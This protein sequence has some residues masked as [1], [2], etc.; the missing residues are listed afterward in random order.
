MKTKLVFGFGS[1]I[2]TA[3][4]LVTS[5]HASDIRPAY[6]KGFRRDFSVWAKGGWSTTNLDLAGIP[7]CALDIQE[8][9]DAKARVNGTVFTVNEND[10]LKLKDRECEYKLTETV[11]YDFKNDE[12]IGKCLVFSACK[13][14]GS[15]DVKSPAQIRYLEICLE[16]TKQYGED[17]YQMFLDTTFVGD[18]R[19][20]DMPELF[21]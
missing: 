11:V 17:F 9:S 14:N 12:P 7:F 21:T 20:S 8:D 1:L 18:K 16:G 4:L 10:F 13:N 5:P 15:Y 3:S 19:L 2:N 6:V